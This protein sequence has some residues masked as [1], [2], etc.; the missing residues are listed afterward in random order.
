[1]IKHSAP[2]KAL[3]HI[4]KRRAETDAWHVICWATETLVSQTGDS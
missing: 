2:Y 1:M 4:L 3:I